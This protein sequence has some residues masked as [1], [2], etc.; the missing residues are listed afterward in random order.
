MNIYGGLILLTAIVAGL[1]GIV[2]VI[3]LIRNPSHKLN[4]YL[5]IMAISFAGWM[6]ANVFSNLAFS[7]TLLL[8]INRLLFVLSSIAVTF[9]PLVLMHLTQRISVRL[10]RTLLFIGAVVTAIAC[11]P[12][13]A[14]GVR[15]TQPVV[16]IIFGPFG[17]LYFLYILVSIIVSV[18]V[19]LRAFRA[20]RGR[21]RSQLQVIAWSALV[22][23]VLGTLTNVVM[24]FFFQQYEASLLGPL[25]FSVMIVGFGYSII[26]QHLFDIRL[27]ISRSITYLV[28]IS[29]VSV[30]Y[31]IGAHTILL[32]VESWTGNV[33]S[34]FIEAFLSVLI[35]LFLPSFIRLVSKISDRVF[36]SSTMSLQVFITELNKL[37]ITTRTIEEL[38]AGL[39][40]LFDV[41]LKPQFV[42]IGVYR[43]KNIDWFQPPD[44]NVMLSHRHLKSMDD[45]V[46]TELVGHKSL[47]QLRKTYA[48]D[49]A[50]SLDS[51][52]GREGIVLF[53]YKRNGSAYSTQDLKLLSYARGAVGLALSNAKKYEEIVAF[54]E[55]MKHRVATATAKLRKVNKELSMLNALKDDFISAASHQ[56]KPQITSAGGFVDLALDEAIPKQI[57]SLLEL[58]R[59]GLN[60]M[61]LIVEGVLDQARAGDIELHKKSFSISRLISEEIAG[62]KTIASRKDVTMSH[63]IP[64]KA[65]I[66]G[67]K[68][69]LREA[70]FNILHN[71]VVYSTSGGDVVVNLVVLRNTVKITVSDTGIGI[72]AADRRRVFVKH[73]RSGV[74]RKHHLGG[75]GLG[76]YVSKMFVESHG[77]SIRFTKNNP[78]GTIFSISLPK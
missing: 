71:A 19:S 49:L 58:S 40:K 60:R 74:A 39:S 14:M 15:P 64:S 47:R 25:F 70:I 65:Y 48:V 32:V 63:S 30:V 6:L 17:G 51:E 55:T 4:K 22:P 1:T 12:L 18:V 36:H 3:V 61:A 10:E 46:Q 59:K 52:T 78:K 11:T 73:F 16:E 56:L 35:V 21:L 24:P 72:N 23:L 34:V 76:L 50:C 38:Y 28:V 31:I 37:L 41:S 29:I 44:T 33:E 2:G 8:W 42:A 68:S 66:S 57:R 5:F 54:N 13:I 20:S 9:M 27:I 26:Q 67:D 75:S 53:G 43:G 69:K 62:L 77:G 7:Y 45:I